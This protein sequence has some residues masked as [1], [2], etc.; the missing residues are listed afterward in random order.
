MNCWRRRRK[1]SRCCFQCSRLGFS[2]L[3]HLGFD[4]VLSFVFHC[5]N[6]CQ[7]NKS[8][9]DRQIQDYLK[10]GSCSC[11]SQL[12]KKVTCCSMNRQDH[13][14]DP[15]LHHEGCLIC[16]YSEVSEWNHGVPLTSIWASC[17]ESQNL[18]ANSELVNAT[19][20]F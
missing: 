10:M 20:L 12:S 14:S 7:R 19:A 2:A 3:F 8:H 4:L 16:P 13:R 18:S 11:C 17:L 1:R 6:R 9:R 5:L 15:C